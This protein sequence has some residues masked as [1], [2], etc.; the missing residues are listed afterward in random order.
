MAFA[1]LGSCMSLS[2][3]PIAEVLPHTV[4]ARSASLVDG[5]GRRLTDLRVSVTGRCNFRCLYCRTGQGEPA[6]MELELREYERLVRNFVALGVE[7]V[8]LTGGEPLLRTGLVDLVAAIGAMR[9][10]DGGRLDLALTTNGFG[11]D[12]LARPLAEAGLTRVTVSLDAVDEATFARVTRVPKAYEKVLAGIRAAQDAGLGPV[13]VNCVLLRGYNDSQIEAFA[14]FARREQV[15]LRFI[16]F[17]PLEESPSPGVADAKAWSR[18]TVV[19]MDEILTRLRAIGDLRPLAPN[20]ASETARRFA[21]A[22]GGAEIGIIAP[23]SHPFCNHCSRLRLTADGK[24]RTCLFSTSDHD[25][26]ALL[27]SGASDEELQGRIRTIVMAK[28]ERHH[29][30]EPGFMKP[31][32]SMVQIGG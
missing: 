17:M 9:R 24:L 29:I 10:P 25:L 12:K 7:K 16:E 6:G 26:L 19:T 14:E 8:R 4:A 23:V 22:D 28:E 20:H 30:G 18:E 27:R 32:R 13:K 21:F 11:L 5:H 2:V 15:I 1:V 31:L 3:S